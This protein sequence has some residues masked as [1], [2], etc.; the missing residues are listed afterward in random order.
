MK[1]SPI[2]E[3][4]I[5]QDLYVEKRKTTY[6]IAEIFQVNRTT[7]CRSLKR[8][9]IEIN[10]KQRKYE[11]IK[12]VPL[13]KEQKEMIVG[14]LLGDGCIAP[15]GRKNK[16]YRLMIGHCDRQKDLVLYKK[17]I[18][19]NL[20]NKI[21]VYTD[22]Y[23]SINH[24][25]S[26]VVHH[27]LKMFYDLFYENSKK[28][29]RDELLNYLTPRS[30]AFWIMDDGSCGKNQNRISIK[31]HTEGFTEEDNIKLQNMLRAGFDIRSKVCKYNRN[32][33]EYCYLSINKE[34]TLK[35]SRLTEEYFIDC[36]KYKIY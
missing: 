10:P 14:T 1:K 4:D 16:N 32:G 21:N 25:F 20:V 34:N 7:V 13:T 22:K 26:T 8:Y 30:L 2:L 29:I 19:G 27:E 11:I 28:I 35:L 31:L 5:L 23:N 33:K 3:K 17:A 6:E 12:K 36:M 24:R 18:L 15:H 9:N